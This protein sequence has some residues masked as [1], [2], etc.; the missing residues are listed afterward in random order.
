[1]SKNEAAG[2]GAGD[3]R[4]ALAA[5]QAGRGY[6]LPHRG[7]MAVALPELY[8]AY[9]VMYRALTV[10]ERHMTPLQR[11]CVWLAILVAC[12]EP[13]GTHH[14][15]AFRRCGGTD[16]DA[17]ALFRQTAWAMGADAHAFMRGE[18]AP[19][20]PGFD[21]AAA[22][23]DGASALN[24]AGELPDETARLARMAVQAAR[25]GLWALETEL[26]AAY[27]AGLDERR[28]AEAISLIIWPRGVNPFVRAAE[29]WLGLLR[30]GR[31]TPSPAFAAWAGVKDQ[32]PLVLGQGPAR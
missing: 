15:A 18:W 16:R 28:M 11:E 26:E 3:V 7:L 30:S 10:D 32:G 25:G 19:H 6:V 20:F 5:L 13:V 29:A 27:G 17:A 14:V 21:P 2:D 9:E 31:V 23:L 12:D 1:M 22:Y 4:A 8:G 24:A